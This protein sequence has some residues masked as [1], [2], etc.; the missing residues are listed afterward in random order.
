MRF[1]EIEIRNF[2]SFADL[3]VKFGPGINVI[4]GLNETG[5]TQVMGA[6][7]AAV[8]GESAVSIE[9]G[10]QSPSSLILS[11]QGKDSTETLTLVIA[12][13]PEGRPAFNRQSS[14]ST[15]SSKE[16]PSSE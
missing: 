7:I 6:V 10:G 1:K 4:E 2:G 5:K 8:L 16:H 13:D 12:I 14:A 15:G 9:H 3:N 11:I